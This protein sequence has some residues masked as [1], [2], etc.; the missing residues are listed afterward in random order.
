MLSLGPSFGIFRLNGIV[1][2]GEGVSKDKFTYAE[3]RARTYQGDLAVF[4]KDKKQIASI[5][6]LLNCLTCCC[7]CC[8][9]SNTKS[10]TK[11]TLA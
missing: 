4:E 9:C 1:K 6:G 5:S 7:C 8:P 2:A 11:K 3:H 10:K